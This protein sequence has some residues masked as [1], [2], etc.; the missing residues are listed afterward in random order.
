[1]SANTIVLLAALLIFTAYH[2]A[3]VCLKERRIRR[4]E[5]V[6]YELYR[7]VG[8]TINIALD[9]NETIRLQEAQIK[10]LR[11]AIDGEKMKNAG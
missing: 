11:M 10:Q 6:I 9:Q 5:K 4:Q 8:R 2:V 3:V 7:S 1:M